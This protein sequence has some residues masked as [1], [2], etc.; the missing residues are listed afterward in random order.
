MNAGFAVL[1]SAYPRQAML[2]ER[3][4]QRRISDGSS[5]VGDGRGRDDGD[6]FQDLFLREAGSD[7]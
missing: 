2:L 6:D 5:V 7:E 4:F 3:V 1:F